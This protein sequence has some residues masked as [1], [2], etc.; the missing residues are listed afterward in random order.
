MRF[1]KLLKE[2]DEEKKDYIELQALYVLKEYQNKD[3]GR[4]LMHKAFEE[5]KKNG[6]NSIIA[7]CL[8]ENKSNG[9]YKKMGGEIVKKRE[10]K[11]P[12]QTLFENVYYYKV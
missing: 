8:E 11:L 7:G 1:L 4:K 2:K 12:N 3:I 10:F 6:F 9:F 5:T